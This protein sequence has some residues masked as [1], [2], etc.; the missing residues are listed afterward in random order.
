[1]TSTTDLKRKSESTQFTELEKDLCVLLCRDGLTMI[2]H[3][4]ELKNSFVK[5]KYIKVTNTYMEVK[6]KKSLMKL[7]KNNL[8]LGLAQE[9]SKSKFGYPHFSDFDLYYLPEKFSSKLP[10]D[11]PPAEY[12]KLV[13]KRKA[14]R[15]FV[16]KLQTT[17]LRLMDLP[18]TPPMPPRNKNK[19]KE[20]VQKENID[21]IEDIRDEATQ[22]ASQADYVAPP[23]DDDDEE[24]EEFGN[25]GAA[26]FFADE[27]KEAKEATTAKK[28]RLSTTKVVKAATPLADGLLLVPNFPEVYPELFGPANSN[29]WFRFRTDAF[30]IYGKDEQFKYGSK[31]LPSTFASACAS[32]AS[33]DTTGSTGLSE[34]FI[35]GIAGG[36]DANAKFS[37]DPPSSDDIFYN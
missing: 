31:L 25:S 5:N 3:A 32:A 6:E 20:D 28:T 8:V 14:I 22:E 17:V 18:E 29:V 4:L 9:P 36:D 11:T 26:K 15:S 37:A 27:A 23:D 1:M 7:L 13:V 10:G 19:T 30:E 21:L 2:H 34:E 35:V 16:T 12:E 24:L 33:V